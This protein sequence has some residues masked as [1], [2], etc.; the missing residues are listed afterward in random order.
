MANMKEEYTKYIELE[1]FNEAFN[2]CYVEDNQQE[3]INKQYEFLQE[4]NCIYNIIYNIN[5]ELI[6]FKARQEK[7][8]KVLD[9]SNADLER[10]NLQRAYL[11]NANLTDANLEYVNLEYANLI[12]AYLRN[13]KILEKD[14][15]FLSDKQK[16]QV[17]VNK[18]EK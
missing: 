14:L 2:N 16:S 4:I 18:D 10:A 15:I 8:P 11:R 1:Q 17:K 13:A 7:S 6:D 9:L 5:G 12:D 3:T